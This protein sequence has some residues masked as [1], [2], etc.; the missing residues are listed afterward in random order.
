M[1][2]SVS[3]EVSSLICMP[4]LID[5][6]SDHLESKRQSTYYDFVALRYSPVAML[7][8]M[9]GVGARRGMRRL[10][11]LVAVVVVCAAVPPAA[12][13][14]ASFLTSR[15]APGER[16]QSAPTQVT[17]RFSE[18][19]NTSLSRATVVDARTAKDV[20]GRSVASGRRLIVRLPSKLARGAYR[21]EWRTVSPLDGHTLGGSLS[22][23]VRAPATGAP[24]V[25]A[26]SP[27]ADG[28]LWRVLARALLYVSLGLFAAS[29]L[30]PALLGRT[31]LATASPAGRTH[32]SRE[33]GL[34]LVTGGL[35]LGGR[36]ADLS[37][38]SP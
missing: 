18:P 30:L 28:G 37:T 15:P 36:R 10:G 3:G 16:L 12:F 27:F 17:L 24:P 21:I 22:F 13:A 4:S 9:R 6:E 35:K 29:V 19:L 11:A 31:W 23:G 33:R 32:R 8:S 5:V 14:H 2:V 7:R 38:T 25:L 1:V 20:R 26:S 34:L